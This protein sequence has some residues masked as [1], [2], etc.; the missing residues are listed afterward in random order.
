MHDY[1]VEVY[2]ALRCDDV[3]SG[4]TTDVSVISSTLTLINCESDVAN[5]TAGSNTVTRF[6]WLARRE[7]EVSLKAGAQTEA[8]F[9]RMKVCDVKGEGA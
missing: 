7:P 9:W 3:Y 1:L 2:C 5:R 6:S 4:T 8:V